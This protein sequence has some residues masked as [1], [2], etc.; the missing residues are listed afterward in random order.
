M[1]K[2]RKTLTSL[3]HIIAVSYKIGKTLFANSRKNT[4]NRIIAHGMPGIL[5]ILRNSKNFVIPMRSY[6]N[7]KLNVRET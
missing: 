6:R 4:R 5:E 1:I 7:D 3:S 2:W